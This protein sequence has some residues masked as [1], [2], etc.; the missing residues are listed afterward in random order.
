MP[1]KELLKLFVT[2]P[3]L[4]TSCV[5]LRSDDASVMLGKT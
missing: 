1:F 4:Q 2:G 3:S 5:G